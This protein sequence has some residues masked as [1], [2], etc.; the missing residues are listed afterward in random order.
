M[1]WK[2][3]IGEDQFTRFAG[4]GLRTGGKTEVADRGKE[5]LRKAGRQE[6]ELVASL[7]P[8]FLLS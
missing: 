8:A 3:S 6:E 2:K 7:P 4:M 5:S 1:G